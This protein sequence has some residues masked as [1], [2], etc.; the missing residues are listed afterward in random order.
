MCDC[1]DSKVDP[2]VCQHISTIKAKVLQML[3]LDLVPHIT[4]K[5]LFTNISDINNNEN[6]EIVIDLWNIID[7][8]YSKDFFYA[9][10]SDNIP[11]DYIILMVFENTFY[12]LYLNRKFEKL[13]MKNKHFIT[14][15]NSYAQ[16]TFHQNN[17][18]NISKVEI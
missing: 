15:E 8:K 11:C 9:D 18:I 1:I 3:N 10:P 16:I 7:T 17:E 4:A 6:K 5:D 13:I 2:K 14:D 12:K